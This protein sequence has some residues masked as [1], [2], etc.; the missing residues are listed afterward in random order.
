[1]QFK[2]FIGVATI[3]GL[4]SILIACGSNQVETTPTPVATMTR[5]SEPEPTE[6]AVLPP[7]PTS[8]PTPEG[9]AALPT[10]AETDV[11]EEA[12]TIQLAPVQAPA[13]WKFAGSR[14]TGVQLAIPESWVDFTG[15]LDDEEASSRFGGL[16]LIV[17]DSK[18]TGNQLIND[19]YESNGVFAFAFTIPPEENRPETTLL[20][21]LAVVDTPP[22]AILTTTVN[23]LAVAYTDVSG[24]PLQLITRNDSVIALRLALF[25][26][27]ENN[28]HILVAMGTSRT[29]FAAANAIFD[30]M[31]T[32]VQLAA[33][34]QLLETFDIPG[35]TLAV[36][37]NGQPFNGQLP[38]QQT[39]YFEFDASG[40]EYVTI[41][42]EPVEGADLEIALLDPNGRTIARGD[43][44]YAYDP[45]L[46]VDAVMPRNGTY[47]IAVSE[48][49]GQDGDFTLTLLINDAPQYTG[50]V[51]EFGQEI[52]SRLFANEKHSWA[53]DGVAGQTISIIVNPLNEQMDIVL[54]LYGPNGEKLLELD[55][56]F[57]GDP[58]IIAGYVLEINGLYTIEVKDFS[59]RNG[60]YTLSLDEGGDEVQNFYDAGDL[61]SGDFKQ[62]VLQENEIQA[63]FFYGFTG[64]EIS[65]IVTPLN[66]NADLM[67]W[68]LSPQLERLASVDD[69]L[70]GE[71]ERIDITLAEDGQYVVLVQDFFGEPGSYQISYTVNQNQLIVN[72]GV[73]PYNNAALAT[74]PAGQI[75]LWQFAAQE[76]EIISIRAT[77]TDPNNDIVIIVRGPDGYLQFTLD[78]EGNGG[79]ELLIEFTIPVA[80]DWTILVR[81]F[82]GNPLSYSLEVERR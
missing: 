50:G 9:V 65:L 20:N 70:A 28:S 52:S 57:S 64:D 6:V 45:E 27:P 73:L 16:Q 62:E 4:T 69:T 33:T 56:G 41:V 29:N 24:D 32:T 7:T 39:I 21:L 78:N 49:F 82:L 22:N 3:F 54:R 53:F 5:I 71:S 38:E 37:S 61:V 8:I 2:R 40:G 26:S 25:V 81:E 44:G 75:A 55:E 77:P 23:D 58:E 14:Q 48:F 30:Q 43:N 10:V 1:M 74:L 15:L 17:A 13:G 67:I 79:E 72:A 46:I 18:E 31:L 42:A 68:L 63:W 35:E 11:D 60:D 76:D 19:S 51:I 47:Y 34:A 36:L 80:G 59:A 12:V 66:S